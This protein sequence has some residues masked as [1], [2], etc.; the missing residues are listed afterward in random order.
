[1]TRVIAG[2]LAYPSEAIPAPTAVARSLDDGRDVT[3]RTRERQR[4]YRLRV[5]AGR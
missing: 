2:E 3:V 1:M 5:P 4:R